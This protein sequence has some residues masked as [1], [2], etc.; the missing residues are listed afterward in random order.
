LIVP[1]S[2][3]VSLRQLASSKSLLPF[4]NT[5]VMPGIAFPLP[6]GFYRGSFGPWFPT[7]PGGGCPPPRGTV[8]CYDCLRPSRSVHFRSLPVPWVDARFFVF[9]PAC[10]E[11]GSS[12]GRVSPRTPGCCLCRS[13]SLRRLF[14]RRRE[15]LPSSRITLVSTCPALRLRWCPIHSPCR[16]SDCCLPFA[17]QRRLW[18]RLPGLILLTTIIHFSEFNDAACALALPLLRT[19]PFGDRPSVRLSTCWLGLGRVGFA[20][21]G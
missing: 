14:P 5:D 6:C 18:V 20:P 2:V 10:A 4:L 11:V 13:P 16:R 1:Q 9:L 12:V 19:P 15:A 17:A 3:P 8:R 21:T 7:R